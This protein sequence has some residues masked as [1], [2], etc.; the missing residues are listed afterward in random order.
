M[1]LARSPEPAQPAWM[2]PSPSV[3]YETWKE[4]IQKLLLVEQDIPWM[5]G[6]C[7][8][9]GESRFSEEA[10][11]AIPLKKKT[12]QSYVAVCERIEPSR[13]RELS[14]SHHKEVAYVEPDIAD[15]LLR[16]AEAEEWSILQL[17]EEKNK[18]APQK[19]LPK[20]KP[21]SPLAVGDRFSYEGCEFEVCE[22][23]HIA[24][25]S[26]LTVTLEAVS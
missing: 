7:F 8:I 18:V 12:V 5:I 16:R 20:P 1:A 26:M 2:P 14:F 6:D 23:Q 17:R 19:A 11:D 15:E 9:W 4:H 3:P 13:R 24:L 10:Y 21:A 25:G 22:I